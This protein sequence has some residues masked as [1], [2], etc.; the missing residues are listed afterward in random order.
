MK[1]RSQKKRPRRNFKVTAWHHRLVTD[2]QGAATA[3]F[4]LPDNV[5][6]YRIMAFAVDRERSAGTGATRLRVDLPM[7]TLP[8]LPR[9]LREGDRA[10][11]GVVLYNTGLPKGT[12]TVTARI[13]GEAVALAG[14]RRKRVPLVKGR[15]Q[16]VRFALEA[17]R[18]G[19]ATFQFTVE[20]AGVTDQLEWPLRV[21]RP[22]VP[23]ASSVSGETRKAVRHGVEKLA[24]LRRDVGGLEVSLA[25]TALTGV[26]DGMD[27]LLRYPYGCLEQVSSR[28]LP[29]IAVAVLGDR[30]SLKLP[31][32]PGTLVRVGLERILSMQ[33]SDGGF[34]YWPKASVSWTWATAYALIV[35]HRARRAAGATGVTVPQRAVKRAIRYLK[36]YVREPRRLGRYGYAYQS[37]L[38]YALA[39]HGRDVSKEALALYAKREHQPLFARALVLSTLTRGKRNAAAKKAIGVLVRE[40]GNSLKIDGTTA[41]AEEGL[42]VGY[43]VLMHSD[44]RTTA[45]VLSALLRAKP[46]HPLITKLVRWFLQGRKQA[47]FRNTQEAAWALMAFWDFAEIREKQVPDFEAGIWLGGSRVVRARF[48]GRSVKPVRRRVPMAEL[49]R[50]AGRA[51][52]D[53]VV[54]K[55]GQG[56][57]YYVARLR[58]ARRDL[59]R[60]PRDHGFAVKK[61]VQV[62]D[63]AGRPLA[64]P[65]PPRLG[66][67]VLVSLKVT[68]PEAR[69]Y[70]VVD[71]PLPAGL[72]PIDTS[73]ATASR[74]STPLLGWRETSRYD[75]RELRDDRA[76]FFRDYAQPGTLTYRYLARV[77]APGRFVAPPTRAAEM[78]NPEIFGHTASRTVSYRPQ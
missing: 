65:R 11:A 5:T 15:A 1:G 3:R 36:P 10:K 30:F 37:F 38:L 32:K 25:S 59:P 78:Y 24:G 75:H 58:Y 48:K 22:A 8:A 61:T 27:Q 67:T 62:L 20:R 4:T 39:L 66:D 14:P 6:A 53:L 44:D 18:K 74:Q 12:A 55:R 40:M 34:G 68:L 52:R 2:V 51:A 13:R 46:A 69:R 31:R 43:Q 64:R 21:T 56:T 29:A 26:E 47:R 35:L 28:L 76:L 41:H 23:E 50:V 42:H 33:R 63:R 70:L 73:L 77:T 45:M 9:F 19:T 71:D 54:A 57:L 7:L 72:E 49:M 17:R 60:K 16:E